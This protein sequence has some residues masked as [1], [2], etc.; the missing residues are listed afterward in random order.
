MTG[1]ASH[2]YTKKIQ[3]KLCFSDTA[4]KSLLSEK[5]L[6][7]RQLIQAF[8]SAIRSSVPLQRAHEC[9][10]HVSFTANL[11]FR[12]ATHNSALLRTEWKRGNLP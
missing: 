12:P 7:P 11:P 9:Y 10:R 2:P 4:Y 5:E 3:Q 1:K 6:H 8:G